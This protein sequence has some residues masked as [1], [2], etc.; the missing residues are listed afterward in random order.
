LFYEKVKKEE[1]DNQRRTAIIL[2]QSFMFATPAQD[3]NSARSKSN[4]WK[5]FLDSLDWDKMINKN[6]SGNS[7]K[8]MKGRNFNVMLAGLGVPIQVI[9]AKEEKDVTTSNG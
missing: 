4:N 3:K 2:A 7:V 5:K 9:P 8:G 1:L 6:K